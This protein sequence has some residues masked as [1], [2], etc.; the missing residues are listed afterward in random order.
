MRNRISE[1]PSENKK[2]NS[3][4][5][6]LNQKSKHISPTCNPA[7]VRSLYLGFIDDP[8]QEFA[9]G[10]AVDLLI[11]PRNALSLKPHHELTEKLQPNLARDVSDH[12]S[13]KYTYSL[14][15]FYDFNYDSE[16]L[17]RPEYHILMDMMPE[18]PVCLSYANP[19]N[20]NW[21]QEFNEWWENNKDLWIKQ[22]RKLFIQLRNVGHDWQFTDT[23]KE[24][25]KGYIRGNELLIDCLKNS[26]LTEPSL[27]KEIEVNLLLPI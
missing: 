12:T 2:L 13:K 27:K 11:E 20:K 17:S 7:A 3:F 24:V 25:I 16:L 23:D 26:N 10:F 6:W 22:L 9:Y 19:V 14:D 1:L 8:I 18:K 5:H 4:L 21:F 15:F